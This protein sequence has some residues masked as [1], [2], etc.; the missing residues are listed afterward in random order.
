MDYTA[1]PPKESTSFNSSDPCQAHLTSLAIQPFT[2][3]ALGRTI[4][5]G[6]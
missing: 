6:N 2:I 4:A 1:I 5:N 3:S